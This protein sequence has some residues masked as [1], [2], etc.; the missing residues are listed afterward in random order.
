MELLWLLGF[1]LLLSM[2]IMPWVAYGS[3]RRM[4]EQLNSLLR[5]VELQNLRLQQAFNQIEQL[6]QAAATTASTAREPA[7]SPI[8]TVAQPAS[9]R[10]FID[11]PV[12]R[13]FEPPSR[14][15]AAE[16]APPIPEDSVASP[17]PEPEPLD[18]VAATRSPPP[19]TVWGAAASE[20]PPDPI[21]VEP[22]VPSELELQLKRWLQLGREW[23]F[24]GNLL[25]KVG[26]LILFVGVA[27]LVRLAAPYFSMPVEIRLAG[28]AAGAIALLVWGWRIRESR[29]GIALP[30]QGAALGIL[31]L[32]TFGA[33]KLFDL[34]PGGAA[35]TVLFVLVAFTCLLAVMQDAV[36]LAIF[37]ICGG[38]AAPILTSTG[39]G[40]HV[41]LFSYYSLLNA[42]VLAIA[43]RRSWR[44]LNVLGFAFTFVVGAAW[45]V[46][47][48]VPENYA[49]AQPFLIVFWLFY[50]AIAVLYGTRR[51]PL[52]KS[53]VDSSLVFG[54][55]TAGMAL[56]YGLIKDV[57]F[58]MAFSAL[59]VALT[60]ASAASLLWRWRGGTLRLLVESF[61]ALAVVFGTLA[62]PLAFDG[63]WTSAVWAVEGAA[64]V[65]IGLKQRQP[66]AW[67]FGMVV[68]LAS[69]ISFVVAMSG[70]DA[71]AALTNNIGL[72]FLLLGGA[73][74]LVALMFRRNMNLQLDAEDR[75]RA[76]FGQFAGGFIVAAAMWLLLGLWA[77]AW[78]RLQG[79][80]RATALVATALLVVFGLHL[81]AKR[82]AWRLPEV[83]GGAVA[84]VAGL[85]FARLML[86]R[87]EW[88]NFSTYPYAR[89]GES[90]QEGP[91]LGGLLLSAGALISALA[92]RRREVGAGEHDVGRAV[93][94]WF[95]LAIFW[96]C[97]F[98]LHGI[99]HAVAYLSSSAEAGST[100]YTLSFWAAYGIGLV[101]SALA[102]QRLAI[103][104]ELLPPL[105]ALQ[106][107]WPT[108]TWL[109]GAVFLLQAMGQLRWARGEWLA[110][111][112]MTLGEMLAAL[113]GSPLSGALILC[114]V[115]AYAVSHMMRGTLPYATT[116]AARE[117]D[118]NHWLVAFG[119]AWYLLLLDPLAQFMG[120]ILAKIDALEVLWRP[121]YPDVMLLLAAASSVLFIRSAERRQFPALR[122]LA[123]PAVF[124]QA[125]ASA[126][127][128][129]E[130][131]LQ[132]DL[133]RLGSGIALIGCWWAVAW[134]LRHWTAN[135]WPLAPQVLPFLHFGRVIAPWLMLMPVIALNLAR[136]IWSEP[137]L[138]RSGWPLSGQWPDY[139]AS[140][141]GILALLALLRQA[142]RGGWPLHPLQDW[143]RTRW[144]PLAA[145]WGVLLA[146]YWNLRQDGSMAPL[147]YLPL[148][149]PLDLTSGFVA[150]L[151]MEVW[152]ANRAEMSPALHLAAIRSS[153]ALVFGWFNLMLLRSASQ[154]LPVP[155]RLDDLYA[156]QFVQAMLSIVWTLSAFALMRFAA[157][158]QLK[159]LWRV[160]VALLTV[161]VVK[162]I[163]VDLSKIGELARTVSFIGVGLLF[164]LIAYIA[165]YQRSDTA[166]DRPAVD[167]P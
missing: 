47:R 153:M 77:E 76:R 131:Y 163:F 123:T 48:Y 80:Q 125:I 34:I 152:R 59:V 20:L 81:L 30:V 107:L 33:F 141:L 27:F 117:R 62:V 132:G 70:L 24:G 54:V 96:W 130:L 9:Q 44:G 82:V 101:L 1:G 144:I 158:R 157:Q 51:A 118:S 161:V 26:L 89:F 67:R 110:S 6:R 71:K 31:M 36:W 155:Y 40:N 103:R 60:Y 63:R 37:G 160:G 167:R 119:L 79:G 66:L 18:S 113:A 151:V 75:A 159:P 124:L 28:V 73:G 87:M 164:L 120:A 45:G 134:S 135:D 137:P 56:Q 100:W 49:S 146:A 68:Q 4:E 88:H 55:P 39:S 52:L 126:V 85:V 13:H 12:A 46:Q 150:L 149:N 69:W 140:W 98:A 83:V 162:L 11:E 14:T 142:E 108:L 2:L 116:D 61:L 8:E 74:V 156:S 92:F 104:R 106:V 15:L 19:E 42:G 102:W 29:R 16:P 90:L 97:G 136:W 115:A 86:V 41:A 22:S 58:G 128:L 145:L 154:Y 3:T 165:R 148:L 78:L 84:V 35:F 166:E 91:L 10:A 7:T 112:P 127:L 53:Y 64:I 21:P 17:Q 114:G 139:I 50:I 94:L 122:W 32:V 133:P 99:A 72:G 5:Q 111:P 138:A 109:G 65:W 129:G 23:L 121:R 25:A 93:T 147:P 105:T 38:F 43:L 95:L 57:E 143:Y